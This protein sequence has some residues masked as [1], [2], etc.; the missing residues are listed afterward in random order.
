M[1][2]ITSS[3]IRVHLNNFGI[4]SNISPHLSTDALNKGFPV[5]VIYLYFEKVFD[6]SHKLHLKRPYWYL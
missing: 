3:H 6:V 5:D 4:I 2:R 1:E